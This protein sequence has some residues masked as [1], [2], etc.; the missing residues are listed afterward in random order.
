MRPDEIGRSYD[1]ITHVWQE[2]RMQS[3]GMSQLE[4]A[5]GFA[6]AR[7]YALDIG[8]GC[9]GRF[10]DRLLADGFHVDGVDISEKMVALARQRHPDVTFHRADIC[11]WDLPR[12]YDL[13]LAW[14]SIWH[15]PL[16]AHVS[17]LQKIC[18]GLT[19]NGVC[20]FTMGGLDAPE[21]KTDACMGPPMYYS[22]PGIPKT[23]DL[24]ARCGC[25]CRHLE[26]DQ[27]PEPHLCVIAQRR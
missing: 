11:E 17:V 3:V 18:E 15:V 14:D 24:L 4:R 22:T 20:L 25:V 12:K 7:R 8:C 1:A 10:I 21:E 16:E 2:P 6:T 9:N 27:Y 13:I 26:Y 23:L 19:P 5:L